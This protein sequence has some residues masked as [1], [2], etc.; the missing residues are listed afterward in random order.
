MD[1]MAC[2]LFVTHLVQIRRSN[3][4]CFLQFIIEKAITHPYKKGQVIGL[5]A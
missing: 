2:R 3:Q 1:K 5:K 4:Y